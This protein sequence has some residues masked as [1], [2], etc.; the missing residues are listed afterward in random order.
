MNSYGKIAFFQFFFVRFSKSPKKSINAY[1]L[2][3]SLGQPI[4]IKLDLHLGAYRDDFNAVFLWGSAKGGS[5]IGCLRTPKM[6]YM[7]SVHCLNAKNGAKSR[8]ILDFGRPRNG[9]KCPYTAQNQ[10]RSPSFLFFRKEVPRIIHLLLS[11]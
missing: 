8:T 4:F 1:N 10:K 9:K 3:G 7:R 2:E 11:T 5:K 6:A